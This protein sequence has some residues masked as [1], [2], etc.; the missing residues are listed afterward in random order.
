VPLFNRNFLLT[1]WDTKKALACLKYLEFTKNRFRRDRAR[2]IQ[3]IYEADLLIY[4]NCKGAMR[5]ISSV[6]DPSVIRDIIMLSRAAAD[7]K[8]RDIFKI[9]K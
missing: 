9:V 4:P 7:L 3:K 5:I 8:S 2:L 6:E 1:V